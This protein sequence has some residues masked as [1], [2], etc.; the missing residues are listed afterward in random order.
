M[1]EE[2]AADLRNLDVDDLMT[3]FANLKGGEFTPGSLNTYKSRFS[4]ALKDFL[5][6][7]NDPLSFKPGIAQRTRKSTKGKL[8]KSSTSVIQE[9][10]PAYLIH[11]SRDTQESIVFPIPIREGVTVKIA[12]LP[13][14][15]TKNEA[16]KIANVISALVQID[17]V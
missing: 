16:L 6:Y 5:R 3:R 8:N 7:K 1:D 11:P 2:E 15:L 17:D 9:E 4:A 12:G 13:S 10:P 14:N